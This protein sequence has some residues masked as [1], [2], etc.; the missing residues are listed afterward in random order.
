MS[1][2]RI[3]KKYPNRRLYD[4]EISK[5]ITL[6]DVKLLVLEGV[7][8]YVKDVKSNQDLTRSV[9]MQIIAEQEHGYE[10]IFS[11]ETLAQIIRSYGNSYQRFLAD[12]LQKSLEMFACQQKEF[13]KAIQDSATAINPDELTE[14]TE[15]NLEL[16]KNMQ[17]EFFKSTDSSFS[18][19]DSENDK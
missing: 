15:R 17:D 5:Y 8:F 16:W 2:K 12:Y 6:E 14:L 4:T 11:T 9:L 13:Q 18:S 10:P 7:D 3:I 1:E 19:L